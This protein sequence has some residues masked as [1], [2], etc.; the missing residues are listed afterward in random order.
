VE[1]ESAKD[2]A[3]KITAADF[4]QTPP[5]PNRM[6]QPNNKDFFK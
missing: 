2:A 1:P 6:R 5:R 4:L 3:R